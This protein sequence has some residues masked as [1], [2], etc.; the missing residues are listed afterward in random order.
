MGLTW[1][2]RV[3][4][5][6]LLLGAAFFFKHAVDN[7]WIGPAGRV[8]IGLL[9]GGGLLA[10]ADRLW[11]RGQRLFA[12][13]LSGCGIAVLYLSFYA[14]AVLYQ[15]VP[16]PHGFLLM[17]VTTGATGALALRYRAQV[18]AVLGLLGGY[19]TPVLLSTGEDRPWFFFGYVLVLSAAGLSLSTIREWRGLAALAFTA[20]ILL[21]FLWLV[22]RL[23]PEKRVVAT[24]FALAYY[25]LFARHPSRWMWPVAQALAALA[26]V[27]IWDPP[28][29]IFLILSTAL[30]AAGLALADRRLSDG[31]WFSFT[32]FW[33]AYAVWHSAGQWRRPDQP[34]GLT[35]LLLGVPFLLYLGWLPWQVLRRQA[36]LRW[37]LLALPAL[38][39]GLYF[40]HGYS[41]LDA[42]YRAFRGLFAAGLA[43]LHLGVGVQLWK[44]Q[45]EDRRDLRPV[46]ILVGIAL[47]LLTLAAPIQFAGYRITMAWTLEA[48]ALAWIAVRAAEV[49]LRVA[50]LAV[51]FLALIRL[52]VVDT[53]ITTQTTVWNLRFLTFLVGA[54]C[55]GATAWWMRSWRWALAPYVAG[56][57][58][59]L[60]GMG[61][62]TLDGVGRGAAPES[63][64][65]ARSLAISV[66]MALYGFTL[67]AAGV[68]T[69]FIVNRLLGLGLV[70]LVIL[71]LYF[72]DIWLLARVYRIAAFTGLGALLLVTSYLYSRHR[73]RIEGW[74]TRD[75]TSR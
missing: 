34:A 11:L 35:W 67:V 74:W 64:A 2:N 8:L 13:G 71:K 6:T 47:T 39:A 68:L 43:A 26:L 66:L 30:A 21:Y 53:G 38:N 59:L 23:Q 27:A 9:V 45:P 52:L 18:I 31:V 58:V 73:D 55:M 42:H 72:S 56:H 65:S 61:L 19:L 28:H 48:A 44:A 46:L 25:G 75:P 51:F 50:S 63:L 7:Q 3:G 41:L 1:I 29:W 60:W 32:S 37:R 62:E 17:A 5:V 10:G 15:L 36:E 69:R 20:T 33:L 40:A 4:A 22:D 24:V 49:R 14:A 16:R 54:S 12:Q 70:G 57:F